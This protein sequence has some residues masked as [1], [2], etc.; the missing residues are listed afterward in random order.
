MEAPLLK[1]V[2]VCLMMFCLMTTVAFGE[3]QNLKIIKP[4]LGPKIDISPA[5]QKRYQQWKTLFEKVYIKE[6]KAYQDLT[7]EQKQLLSK[8]R[9]M[10]NLWSS[11]REDDTWYEVGGPKREKASSY[12]RAPDGSPYDAAL[13]HDFDLRTAWVENADDDGIGEYIVYYFE[14]LSPPVDEIII[15]NGYFKSQQTWEYNSRVR[16]FK[17]YVNDRPYAILELA[18]I[19]AAQSFK[20]E[21]LQSKE[22]GQDLVLKLEILDYFKGKKTKDVAVSEI[23]FNGPVVQSLAQGTPTPRPNKN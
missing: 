18:D 1:R 5:A 22:K 17:L 2:I 21:P 12:L 3:G 16:R 14:A 19:R 8:S 23:N 11:I 10:Q 15:Y 6:E 4:K 20:V 13:A 7:R 9:Q